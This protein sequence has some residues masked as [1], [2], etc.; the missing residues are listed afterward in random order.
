MKFLPI[1]LFISVLCMSF[2]GVAESPANL[3]RLKREVTIFQRVVS[4]A[5]Q[6]DT[7]D[8]ISSVAGSYLAGQGVVI[9]IS[10]RGNNRFNW[11]KHI[12][13]MRELHGLSDIPSPD[14]SSLESQVNTLRDNLA[15]VS[16]DAYQVALEAVK[17]SA[18]QIREIADQERDTR[19]ELKMLEREQSKISNILKRQE[20]KDEELEQ[21][22]ARL[23]KQIQQ[24]KAEKAALENNKVELREQLTKERKQNQA[25]YQT[26]QTQLKATIKTSIVRSLCDYGN[27]LRSVNSREHISFQLTFGQSKEKYIWVFKKEDVES[28]VKNSIQADK[29]AS[30]ATQYQF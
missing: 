23:E 24:L 14:F 28:C 25:H 16:K 18:E 29:L 11:R 15:N 2:S 6:H 3:E 12:E 1:L 7:R 8:Q 10:L 17:L 27:G 30:L 22:Q 9:D 13:G 4:T 21:Q 26:Q 20:E 19:R 5:L